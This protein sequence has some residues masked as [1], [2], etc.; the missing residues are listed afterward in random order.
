MFCGR[1]FFQWTRCIRPRQVL[2]IPYVRNLYSSDVPPCS[3]PTS[4]LTHALFHTPA[5]YPDPTSR[6]L[7]MSGPGG[8]ASWGQDHGV[9]AEANE[10]LP[11]YQRDG[12]QSLPS[13]WKGFACSSQWLRSRGQPLWADRQARQ[14]S[15]QVIFPPCSFFVYNPL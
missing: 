15:S 3:L 13:R 6:F 7:F 1:T 9:V 2:T 4:A 14:K 11:G 8:V 5:P 10:K 12:L